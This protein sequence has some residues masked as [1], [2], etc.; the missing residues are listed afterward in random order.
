[1][2]SS[3]S[4]KKELKFK[5][6]GY[7]YFGLLKFQFV[8]FVLKLCRQSQLVLLSN[9]VKNA[10][11]NAT[12][13]HSFIFFQF[14][15][16]KKAYENFVYYFFFSPPSV[17]PTYFSH[18]LKNPTTTTTAARRP[19][20][21]TLTLCNWQH[22]VLLGILVSTMAC[23]YGTQECRSLC[24]CRSQPCWPLSQADQHCG[25]FL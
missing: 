2:V 12:K 7:Y 18:S 24:L 16:P 22:S 20:H 13:Q 4:E 25:L 3:R 5:L 8:N 1:M 21:F 19:T 6:W 9:N 14:L 15:L 10:A 17:D 11:I 23:V